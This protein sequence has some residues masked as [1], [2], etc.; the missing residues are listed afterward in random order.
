MHT[1]VKQEYHSATLFTA[2]M[3]IKISMVACQFC[4]TQLLYFICLLFTKTRGLYTYIMKA[5]DGAV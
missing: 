2:S 3:F 5:N 4:T 1:S